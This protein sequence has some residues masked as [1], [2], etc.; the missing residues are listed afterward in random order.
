MNETVTLDQLHAYLEANGWTRQP[1]GSR[2]HERWRNPGY[3]DYE[4]D[5]VTFPGGA[6]WGGGGTDIYLSGMLE[7]FARMEGCCEHEILAD[8]LGQPDPATLLKRLEQAREDVAI[9]ARVGRMYLDA[10]DEDPENEF[11]TLGAAMLVTQVREAVERHEGES[12]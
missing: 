11:L 4:D 2:G 8:M 6:D 1:D 7:S 12:A 3:G 9:L 10:L 5:G